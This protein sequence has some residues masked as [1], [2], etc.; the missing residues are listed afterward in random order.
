MVL[1]TYLSKLAMTSISNTMAPTWSKST[2]TFR[3]RR[4]PFQWQYTQPFMDGRFQVPSVNS[5]YHRQFRPQVPSWI[6]LQHNG[7][8][9][10]SIYNIVH[11]SG[12]VT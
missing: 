8:E 1:S 10:Q 12:W 3:S 7:V 9:I 6:A 11:T 4:L 5:I 2:R